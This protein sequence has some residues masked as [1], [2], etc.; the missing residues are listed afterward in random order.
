MTAVLERTPST[1]LD[2][3]SDA[4]F[5]DPYT[6]YHELRELAPVFF[7]EK[8]GVYGAARHAEVMAILQDHATFISGAGAGIHDLR[9]GN[10]WRPPSILLEADPP[11]MLRQK[12]RCAWMDFSAQDGPVSAP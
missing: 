12:R 7:I 9:K 1:S 10:A 3:F 5:A 8:Y 2:P 4:F 11:I 6:R